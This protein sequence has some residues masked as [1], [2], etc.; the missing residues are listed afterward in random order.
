MA[1]K[2]VAKTAAAGTA[3][4]VMKGGNPELAAILADIQSLLAQLSTATNA[5]ESGEEEDEGETGEGA[6]NMA[7][8]PGAPEAEDEE[9]EDVKKALDGEAAAEDRLVEIAVDDEKALAAVAKALLRMGAVGKSAAV[10]KPA[11]DQTTLA[12]GA[13][14]KSLTALTN[15]VNAQG[16]ALVGMMEGIGIADAV[17]QKSAEISTKNKKVVQNVDTEAFL[18]SLAG[19]VNKSSTAPAAEPEMG[20]GD[21]L[22]ALTGA[23]QQ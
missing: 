15:Q 7:A 21:A 2:V 16:E 11:V 23:I 19:L 4:P 14:A 5:E 22:M 1:K 8:V 6:V 3:A 10:R 17:V 13:I 9:E 12:L 20:L 18:K